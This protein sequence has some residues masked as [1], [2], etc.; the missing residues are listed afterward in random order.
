PPP[1]GDRDDDRYEQRRADDRP[2]ERKLRAAREADHEGLRQLRL[3]LEPGSEHRADEAE[4]DRG[5][6]AS[7]GAA[8]D[9]PADAA[10]DRRD[11]Q[12]EQEGEERQLHSQKHLTGRRWTDLSGWC[13]NAAEANRWNPRGAGP[14]RRGTTA[15]ST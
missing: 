11:Q 9:G 13:D 6:T 5:Q 1:P 14:R 10:R 3:A 7:A 12:E 15:R 2:E 4:R 8:R